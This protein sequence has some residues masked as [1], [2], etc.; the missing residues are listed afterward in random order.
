MYI[1]DSYEI[2]AASALTFVALVR[3][4]A[5]G[6]MT[7][8]GIPFYKNLG[9]QYTLTIMACIAAVLTPIPYALYIWG[10]KV[11]KLSKYAVNKNA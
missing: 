10:P 7:V 1:I 9:S 8:V 5:A 11:R 6:G 2:Y 3:Y 4:I